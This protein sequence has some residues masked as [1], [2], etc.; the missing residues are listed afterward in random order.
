ML[1]NKF[2]YVLLFFIFVSL[3]SFVTAFLITTNVLNL[4]QALKPLEAQSVEVSAE[5]K[6]GDMITIKK[7]HTICG[8]FEELD[9]SNLELNVDNMDD[10]D[11]EELLIHFPPEDGWIL[12]FVEGKWIATQVVDMLCSIDRDKRHLR[13]VDDFIAVYQG[14]PSYKEN[15]LFITEIPIWALPD[16]WRENILSGATYFK[17]ERELLQALDS[18]DEFRMAF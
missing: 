2:K 18:L 9:S 1:W 3:L 14:P 4:P 7:F 16:K 15:L 10:L 13:V 5:E 17:D 12:D 11:I 8:H 6:I